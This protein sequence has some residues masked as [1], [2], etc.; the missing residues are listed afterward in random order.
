MFNRGHW[1]KFKD[2]PNGPRVGGV[3]KGKRSYSV[4]GADDK[5]FATDYLADKAIDFIN[6]NSENPFCYMVSF[7]DP[8]G[9]NSVRAPYDTMY[10]DLDFQMPKTA[11]KS[12]EGLPSWATKQERSQK[13]NKASMGR[14]FGMVKCIDDNVKKI[15][16]SLRKKGILGNTIVVFTSDHGDLCYEHGR[17]NKGVPLEASAKIPFVI[18]NPGKI[19]SGTVV[20]E[21]MSCVD[22]MPTIL[23]L[24]GVESP[25]TEGRDCSALL[26]GGKAP[27]GWNDVVFIRG[28]GNNKQGWFGAVTKRYK[29]IYCAGDEPWLYDLEKDPDELINFYNKPAYAKIRKK[30]A[31]DILAYGKKYKDNR[32]DDS[33][34]SKQLKKG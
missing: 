8:H 21:A 2:T 22:F 34:V 29:M 15:L 10:K 7:P 11:L 6:E 4:E 26:T 13:V 1:K 17:H 30:L 20:D 24:M 14:Y 3:T 5:S 28:T 33:Q 32:I 9:P 12:T 18:Y 25:K 19:K 27:A 31:A 16:D 23:N